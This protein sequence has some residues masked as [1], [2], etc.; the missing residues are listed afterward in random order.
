[1]ER[2]L[3]DLTSLS[4]A[5]VKQAARCFSL[6]HYIHFCWWYFNNSFPETSH[7]YSPFF[8]SPSFYLHLVNSWVFFSPLI[9]FYEPRPPWLG[10]YLS[11]RLVSVVCLDHGKRKLHFL[12]WKETT[13][14]VPKSANINASQFPQKSLF[15]YSSQM[16]PSLQ[17]PEF[18]INV[19]FNQFVFCLGT[20]FTS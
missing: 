13:S 2:K 14:S 10:S 12:K 19:I 5:H 16:K 6:F 20:G 9:R 18:N 17:K 1:M 15:S 4:H 7:L 3:S 11:I 8:F